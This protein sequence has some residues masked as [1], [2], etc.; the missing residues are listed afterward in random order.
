M[1]QT[2]S[3]SHQH[4]Q[5][6]TFLCNLLRVQLSVGRQ[7]YIPSS[8]LSKG[9]M[10][11]FWPRERTGFRLHTSSKAGLARSDSF[12]PNNFCIFVGN[13]VERR[14]GLHSQFS[15]PWGSN[16]VVSITVWRR[17]KSRLGGS[18]RD[19]ITG[20]DGDWSAVPRDFR[21]P[22]SNRPW[23]STFFTLFGF[24]RTLESSAGSL[25]DDFETLGAEALRKSILFCYV[26]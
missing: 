16:P 8:L 22:L 25:S 11:S 21:Q 17:L 9:G 13:R 24:V 14:R 6:G 12:W 4:E 3:N 19:P 18:P 15:R 1:S 20:F 26:R 5:I 10:E 7:A 23:D 2:N